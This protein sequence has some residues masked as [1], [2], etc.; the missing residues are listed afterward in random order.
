MSHGVIYCSL[1]LINKWTPFYVKHGIYNEIPVLLKKKILTTNNLWR[2][3]QI[4]NIIWSKHFPSFCDIWHFGKCIIFREFHANLTIVFESRPTDRPYLFNQNCRWLYSPL[5]G[6]ST[7]QIQTAQQPLS[8]SFQIGFYFVYGWIN[9]ERKYFRFVEEKPFPCG[10][11][12]WFLN[13]LK[14]FLVNVI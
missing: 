9:S 14:Y 12:H 5:T 1:D 4:V 2:W 10:K 13:F 7:N 6:F 3:H 11:F 8:W